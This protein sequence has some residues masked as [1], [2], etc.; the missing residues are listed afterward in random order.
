VRR[1]P[2][3]IAPILATCFALLCS[4]AQVVTARSAGEREGYEQIL[5]RFNRTAPPSYRAYRK[6]QAGLV[7]SDKRAT[8]EVWT[9]YSP[10]H[11]FAY[12]IVQENG[13]DYVRRKI[14]KDVLESEKELIAKG[15]PLH[16]PI[17]ARN[18]GFEDGGLT[19]DGL[20]KITLKAAR[21]SDGIINGNVF[22]HPEDGYVVRMQ[23][24]LVKSPSFWLRDVD[25]TWKF[26]RIGGHVMPTEVASTGRVRIFGRSDF[27]MVYEYVSVDGQP[28]TRLAA[29]TGEKE[30]D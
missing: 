12:E 19:D 29:V 7:D 15:N 1:N 24:R 21:K 6:M 20:Q 23:G 30:K 13:S 9:S 26:A 22:L 27:R 17:V 18:Y 28:T 4:I 2:L 10:E 5:A 16:A 14:L 25:V 8:M 3:R 11:G